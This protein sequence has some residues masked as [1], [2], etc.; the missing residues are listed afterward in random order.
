M[1]YGIIQLINFA[2]GEVVMVGAMV[3]L[4]VISA[5]TWAQIGRHPAADAG[6]RRLVACCRPGLHGGRLPA[7]SASRTGRCA[8]R[9]G[10]APLITAI[11][12]AI[13]LQH[14]RAA[15][16]WS[17]ATRSSFPQI[18][19]KSVPSTIAGAPPSAQRAD[20]DHRHLVRR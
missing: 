17:A 15:S 13:I 2:H 7:W 16:I 3:A 10:L 6:A 11:G 14:G 8:R 18:M 19:P 1:V 20:R 4:T 12:I 5:L 9:R